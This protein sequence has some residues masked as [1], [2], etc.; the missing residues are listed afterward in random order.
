MDKENQANAYVFWIY[1]TRLHVFMYSLLLIATPF[2]LLRNYLVQAIAVISDTSTY[3]FGIELK[4]IP[5]IALIIAIILLIVFRSKITRLRILAVGLVVLLNALAQQITDYYFD[6]NFYD[7]QQNWHYL[8]YGLYAYII[9]RDLD[10]RGFPLY[11]MLAMT[12]FSALGLSTFDEFF[13]QFMSS[14]V[15]DVCDIGKD[16]WGVYM[17]MIIVYFSS[18]HSA[19]LFKDWR[20]IHYKKL[21]YYYKNPFTQMVLLFVLSVIFLTIGSLLTE[22]EFVFLVAGLTIISF[23]LFFAILHLS[24]FKIAKYIFC[25]TLIA[26]LLVQGFFFVQY[27]DKGIV[28]NQYGL[29]IY[30]GIPVPFFDIMIF[31]DD[32]FRLVD[33]KH[34]FNDRDLAF[35]FKRKPDIILIGSGLYGKGG[36][37][38]V[39]PRHAFIYNSY[40]KGIAQIIIQRNGEACKT[41]NRLKRENKN[42]LFIIHNTC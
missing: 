1:S 39:D 13:Q 30:K 25:S 7:L 26:L 27:R 4:L 12:Y 34:Y 14:R 21:K 11:K 22:S 36:K 20:R 31:P 16:V 2:I 18:K 5:L 6:H 32:T 37:G 41:F 38:F 23:L 29:T 19:T 33:K 42:V 3:P 10:P 15:F 40:T 35:L 8:A 24:Q 9:Y 28:Y 17:G